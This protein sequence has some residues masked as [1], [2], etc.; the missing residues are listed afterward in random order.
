MVADKTKALRLLLCIT[1]LLNDN[2]ASNTYANDSYIIY[3]GEAQRPALLR[4][5]WNDSWNGGDQ[6]ATWVRDLIKTRLV[7]IVCVFGIVGNILTLLVLACEKLRC[8]AGAERKVN[9]WLQALAVSDLLLCVV[10]LPHG[11]MTYGGRLVYTSLSFQLLY[12]AYGS[13]VI[14]N[15]M[16]TSTWLTVAMSFGRYMAVCHPLGVCQNIPLLADCTA[17]GGVSSRTR[18]KAGV[19][20]LVC[21]VFNLP[22]FFEFRIESHSCGVGTEDSEQT[23][24]ALSFGAVAGGY[25][26]AYFV[27]AIVLPLVTLAFCNIRLVNTLRQSQKFRRAAQ[28]CVI[29]ERHT[30][31]RGVTTTLAWV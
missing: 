15:F 14:N 31:G 20:F 29:D 26:W 18:V 12:Q 23:V 3:R 4:P 11:L 25:V 16:L 13:A 2:N 1:G 6:G 17:R 21:F 30:A 19:I 10:L 27:V 8:D 5:V 7:P 24:L 28:H 9:L 22:R